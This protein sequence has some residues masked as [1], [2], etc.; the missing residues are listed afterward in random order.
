MVALGGIKEESHLLFW[1]IKSPKESNIRVK[2]LVCSLTRMNAN[3]MDF[4]SRTNNKKAVCRASY[5]AVQG[6]KNSDLSNKQM[7]G[8]YV[9]Q[10]GNYSKNPA[11]LEGAVGLSKSDVMP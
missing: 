5:A 3:F 9:A 11:S 10:H 7:S 4:L 8:M 2:I 6:A 1:N